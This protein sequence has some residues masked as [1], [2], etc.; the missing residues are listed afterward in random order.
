MA[1][2]Q[3]DPEAVPLESSAASSATE[4][5][6]IRRLLFFAVLLAAA[7]AI[8]FAR[9]VLL[10]IMIAIVLTLTL[11]PVVR[12]GA[13]L[14]IPA[15]VTAIALMLALGLG[16]VAGGYFL[17]GPIQNVVAD[18]PRMAEAVQ[19]RVGGFLD[20]LRDLARRADEMA[21]GATGGGNGASL[22]AGDEPAV[23]P[24]GSI[25]AG[26]PVAVVVEADNGTGAAT[27]TAAGVAT[28]VLASLASI[29]GTIF[30]ALLLTGFL[31][32][33]GDFY[34]RR[35]VEAAPRLRD[36]KKALTIIRDVERQISRYLG[37]I[38]LINIGLGI[39]VGT[40]MWFWGMP[41][42]V[43]WGIL[44]C[45]LN[46]IPFVGFIV[47][48]TLAT[49]V[50]LITFDTIWQAALPPLFYL[51][52]NALE[53]NVITP[54]LVGRRL[55]IN[56]VSML[57]AVAF[58]MWIWGIP[59]AVLAVPFLV[60]VKAISDNVE[61]LQVLSSFLSAEP[62]EREGE[63]PQKATTGPALETAPFLA[64]AVARE[65]SPPTQAPGDPKPPEVADH[66]PPARPASSVAA[67]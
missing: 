57:L 11:L 64:Q 13:R 20:R 53:G 61:S 10:P 15:G 31:L 5:R 62:A 29:G 1:D 18:A 16:L 2:P 6:R 23:A 51:L 17:S 19:D 39:A 54:M 12:L 46:F 21:S 22:P 9:Q 45:L 14:R 58:W 67:I 42:P 40:S 26:P 25:V 49:A 65:N 47:G 41:A 7:T 63:T 50:S 24:D 38:T 34:H 36:K 59:G 52:I 56:T 35:I 27:G 4:L 30:A 3:P 33:A 37:S 44:A 60:V 8:Y 66:E 28:A 43:L 32:A 55:E 48:V